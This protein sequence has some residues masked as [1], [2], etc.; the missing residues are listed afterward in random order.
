MDGES[1]APVQAG[2]AGQAVPGGQPSRTRQAWWILVYKIPSEPS[3]L[4]AAVWRAVR[5]LGAVYLQ[6]GVCL[7]PDVFD[8]EL[9]LDALREKIAGM[10]GK[11]WTFRAESAGEGQDGDLEGL[12]RDVLAGELVEVRDAA[13]SLHRH[14]DDARDHFDMEGEDIARSESELRRLRSQLQAVR[15]RQFFKEPLSDEI[16]SILYRCH[17]LLTEG[18]EKDEV[19][20]QG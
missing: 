14:L 17:A 16:D 3:R 5:R 8:V 4:R 12:F 7:V 11:A 2:Q 13:R 10:G 15:A 9:N 18:G 1:R 20:H 19:G 6:D